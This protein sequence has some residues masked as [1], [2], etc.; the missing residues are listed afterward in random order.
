MERAKCGAKDLF[1][2]SSASTPLTA[3][4]DR[5]SSIHKPSILVCLQCGNQVGES[6]WIC[7]SR[8]ASLFVLCGLFKRCCLLL[9]VHAHQ[10]LCSSLRK[11]A[12][13]F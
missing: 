3:I 1:G 8:F 11:L 10:T 12:A 5:S 2:G 9:P 13:S 7:L 4:V 6:G